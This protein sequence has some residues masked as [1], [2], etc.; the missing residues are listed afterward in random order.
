M[1]CEVKVGAKHS[2]DMNLNARKA[3]TFHICF[4]KL[5]GS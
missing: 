2:F 1:K 3:L 5:C 4:A